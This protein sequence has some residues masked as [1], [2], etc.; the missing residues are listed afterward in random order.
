MSFLFLAA[1]EI[2]VPNAVAYGPRV[3]IL[4]ASPSLEPLL[5]SKNKKLSVKKNQNQ[6]EVVLTEGVE[7]GQQNHY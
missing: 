1:N 6:N 7:V 3:S 5:S 4:A 2:I